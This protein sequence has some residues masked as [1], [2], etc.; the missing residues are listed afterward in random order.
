MGFGPSILLT[1]QFSEQFSNLHRKDRY[2]DV[3]DWESKQLK[4]INKFNIHK[5]LEIVCDRVE[6]LKSNPNDKV[7]RNE[8][9]NCMR[10]LA[11]GIHRYN[12]EMTGQ[13]VRY[14]NRQVDCKLLQVQADSQ[15][16]AMRIDDIR[17]KEQLS[18]EGIA[19]FKKV[20]QEFLDVNRPFTKKL[21][22]AINGEVLDDIELENGFNQATSKL[23]R[24]KDFFLSNLWWIPVGAANG[25]IAGAVA[26]G[27][28]G[29]YTPIPIA[30]VP[31][32]AVGAGLG[33][34]AGGVFGGVALGIAAVKHAYKKEEY[35][36]YVKSKYLEITFE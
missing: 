7:S 28:V 17:D 8:L 35:N 22:K 31:G 20:A 15:A 11:Q 14:S 18:P 2:N 34:V 3:H 16:I 36:V 19:K 29:A 30:T 23:S 33:A 9:G 24:F 1:P 12:E 4:L 32:I 13:H 26:G 6:S 25:A 21:V 10:K 27:V 5:V